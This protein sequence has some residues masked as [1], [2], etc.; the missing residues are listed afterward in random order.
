MIGVKKALKLSVMINIVYL[1]HL[2]SEHK[3]GGGLIYLFSEVELSLEISISV[4]SIIP[5]TGTTNTNH[6]K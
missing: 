3:F 5:I 4:F 1:Y 2:P 6:P